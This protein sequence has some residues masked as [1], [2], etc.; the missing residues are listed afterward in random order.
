MYK[1]EMVSK[2]SDFKGLNE[3]SHGMV[4][5]LSYWMEPVREARPTP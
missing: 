4:T 1:R 5:N 3:I 2:Y